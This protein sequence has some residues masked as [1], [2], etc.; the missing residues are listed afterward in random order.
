MDIHKIDSKAAWMMKERTG[1]AAWPPETTTMTARP[2]HDDTH[3][4]ALWSE[5]RVVTAPNAMLEATGSQGQSN[6]FRVYYYSARL[7][8]F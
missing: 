3:L 1:W 4:R 6:D 7:E 2:T 8:C 5:I